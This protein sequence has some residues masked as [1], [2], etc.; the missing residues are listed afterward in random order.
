MSL[1]KKM[2][3]EVDNVF[4]NYNKNYVVKEQ[5]QI[6]NGT[7]YCNY[8]FRQ[9]LLGRP[10]DFTGKTKNEITRKMKQE[11]GRENFNH[12]N[13]LKSRFNKSSIPVRIECGEKTP[14]NVIYR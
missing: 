9:A 12:I 2:A 10:N 14:F 13:N 6:T 5:S 7:A 3:I 8:H 4:L 1:D 11:T